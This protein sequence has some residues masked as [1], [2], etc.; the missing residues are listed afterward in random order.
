MTVKELYRLM[1]FSGDE[2]RVTIANGALATDVD[3]DNI[4]TMSAYGSFVVE[5]VSAIAEDAFEIT[6][7]T[8]P[9]R[10][11]EVE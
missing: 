7:A 4:I 3:L 10:A 5:N 9:I 11:G 6:I 2:K 8:K 1:I